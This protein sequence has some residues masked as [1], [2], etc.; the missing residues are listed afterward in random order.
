M[1]RSKA[2]VPLAGRPLID[3]TLAAIKSAGLQAV[4]IAKADSDLPPLP[5][6]LIDEPVRPRHP[7]C[8]IVAALE[9][10]ATG[11][12]AGNT[13]EPA[14]RAVVVVACDMPLLPGPFL[15]WL[16]SRPGPLVVPEAEGH[17]QPLAARYDTELL[18]ALRAALRTGAPVPLRQTVAELDPDRVGPAELARFGDPGRFLLNINTGEDLARAEALLGGA[19]ET[20]LPGLT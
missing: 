19:G 17:L 5:C 12:Q 15:A 8:G 18:P 14:R 4:V 20:A 10:A 9:H 1:G 3:H 16:A 6:P 2:T 7:L 13:R 11:L